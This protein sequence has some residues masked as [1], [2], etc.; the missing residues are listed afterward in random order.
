MSEQSELGFVLQ[1]IADHGFCRDPTRRLAWQIG[2]VGLPVHFPGDK[3]EWQKP[4][5]PATVASPSR[6]SAS[7]PANEATLARMPTSPMLSTSLLG[8]KPQ[9]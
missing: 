1:H 8:T 3:V 5:A 2:R 6:N 4:D 9:P 7:A